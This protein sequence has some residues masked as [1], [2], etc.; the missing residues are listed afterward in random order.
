MLDLEVKDVGFAGIDGFGEGDVGLP[1]V[2]A[3]VKS[4]VEVFPDTLEVELVLDAD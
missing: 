4:D 1:E 2:L 3:G